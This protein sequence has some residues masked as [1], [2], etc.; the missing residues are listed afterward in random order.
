MPVVPP[1]SAK[2]KLST[3]AE[4]L[5]A[6]PYL[7]GFTPEKSFVAICLRNKQVGLTMRVDIEMATQIRD[8]MIERMRADDADSAVFIL[9]DP[10]GSPGRT[11]PGSSLMR[12][13]TS[14]AERAGVQTKDA[15]GIRAGRYWSYVCKDASCCPP[16]GLPMPLAGAAAHNKV[17]A[18]FIATG[19]APLASR[20]ALEASIAPVAGAH[21]EQLDSAYD[22]ALKQPAA[23]PLERWMEAVRRYGDGVPRPRRALSP[24]ESVRLI[25]ALQNVLVRDE[26][27]SWTSDD[28]LSGV[29]AVLRH[30]APLALPPFETQVLASLAWAAFANGDGALASVALE[31]TLTV[32]PD[33]R[34]A[35]LLAA[36]LESGVTPGELH[37]VSRAMAGG[38]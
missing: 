21:F 14:A 29:L 22:T 4:I 26:V 31:R 9:F 16:E 35:T 11:R 3:P 17:A 8:E 28:G 24:G 36:A 25:V 33:H 6:V 5:A 2:L 7:L 27:L 23:Y 19:A 34:L 30:L 20:E 38:H 13:L 12:N 32:D 10:P 18:P 1:F 37:R 15:L